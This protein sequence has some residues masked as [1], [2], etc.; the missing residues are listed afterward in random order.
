MECQLAEQIS[1]QIAAS[2]KRTLEQ[3]AASENHELASHESNVI[4]SEQRQK[5]ELLALQRRRVIDSDFAKEQ[6]KIQ[7]ESTNSHKE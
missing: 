4:A 5:A 2:E 3:I 1:E 6:F 7:Y